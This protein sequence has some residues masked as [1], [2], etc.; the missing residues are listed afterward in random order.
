MKMPFGIF[1]V[2]SFQATNLVYANLAKVISDSFPGI[3]IAKFDMI[4]R[5]VKM[6]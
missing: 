6:I 4:L 2:F 1:L 3:L 5:V